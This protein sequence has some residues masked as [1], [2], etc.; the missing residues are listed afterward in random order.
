VLPAPDHSANHTTAWTL[1]L[2]MALLLLFGSEILLWIDP[3][4]RSLTDWSLLVVGYIALAALLLDLA[5]RYRLRNV[6][7]AMTLLVLYALYAGLLLNPETALV[8]FP[9]TF[10]TR[11]IGAH[12]LLGL[13][14]FGLFLALTGGANTRTLRLLL[15]FSLW[16]GFYWGTW[17]QGVALL[18]DWPGDAVS[19]GTMFAVAGVVLAVGLI[20]FIA[21]LRQSASL[22]PP[23]LRLSP[24]AF[25]LA[26]VVLA[27]LFV[28]RLTEDAVDPGMVALT[29]A[30]TVL[31]IGVLW[32][33]RPTK[34]AVLLDAHIPPTSPPFVLLVAA[35]G[36]FA[37][38]AAFGYHL[39]LL[40]IAGYSQLSL[41]EFGFAGVGTLWL[42]TVAAVVSINGMDRVG[43]M[44]S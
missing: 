34:G 5:A 10:L 13:E 15:G 24:V 44:R 36:I 28:V 27:G 37:G 3:P 20:L 22:T 25:T 32:F 17:G 21:A 16:I 12:S 9:R 6:Y 39:P 2:L 1:R 14:M 11:V 4:G 29:A 7:D 8:D 38:A 26:L 35:L 23:D 31:G 42:P 18:A 19:L 40:D 41:M 43:R 30:L 33:Q